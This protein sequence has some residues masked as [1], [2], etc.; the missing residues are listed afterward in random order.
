M[1]FERCLLKLAT[2]IFRVVLLV[3]LIDIGTCIHYFV[4][5]D[6]CEEPR[7]RSIRKYPMTLLSL[8]LE[9]KAPLDTPQVHLQL[10]LLTEQVRSRLPVMLGIH[11][12][13]RHTILRP[14]AEK[15]WLIG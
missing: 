12:P 8:N 13:A 1:E 7:A 2:G 5:I 4:N 9:C 10:H 14:N 15:T 3:G 6:I 11:T